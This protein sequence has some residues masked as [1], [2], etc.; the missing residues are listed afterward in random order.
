MQ[1]EENSE[2]EALLFEQN[3]DHPQEVFRYN[4]EEHFYTKNYNHLKNLFGEDD[5]NNLVSAI[6][7]LAQ[8]PEKHRDSILKSLEKPVLST[9]V[10]ILFSTFLPKTAE[11][12]SNQ[13]QQRQSFEEFLRIYSLG[14]PEQDKVRSDYYR[15]MILGRSLKDM[16]HEFRIEKDPENALGWSKKQLGELLLR[17]NARSGFDEE[18]VIFGASSFEPSL[19]RL[20]DWSTWYR[21]IFKKISPF[22]FE[23]RF[24]VEMPKFSLYLFYQ[25]PGMRT[26]LIYYLEGGFLD[27]WRKRLHIEIVY[28]LYSLFFEERKNDK[29][30]VKERVILGEIPKL[31]DEW[32]SRAREVVNAGKFQ[33]IW[34]QILLE[35]GI[36]RYRRSSI[37]F[38]IEICYSKFTRKFA[39]KKVPITYEEGK[40]GFKRL[41]I[42][43]QIF[44][45]LQKIK[46]HLEVCG[47]EIP[48]KFK[49]DTRLKNIDFKNDL[50]KAFYEY[51][52]KL[53]KFEYLEKE[54]S[55]QEIKIL[56]QI[57]GSE[58]KPT[59]HQIVQ[60]MENY[61][62]DCAI[63]LK[64]RYS[65]IKKR[66]SQK[67]K[68]KLPDSILDLEQNQKKRENWKKGGLLRAK[69]RLK[70]V[71][72]VLHIEQDRF[73]SPSLSHVLLVELDH[74]VREA[75]LNL[76]LVEF[77]VKLMQKYAK[78]IPWLWQINYEPAQSAIDKN[79]VYSL[80]FH[81][82]VNTT[83]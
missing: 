52:C 70:Y 61:L 13:A 39:H 77:L 55:E 22:A 38:I 15:K 49:T 43:A 73:A 5:L 42:L 32:E 68:E 24:D 37:K 1:I 51:L 83:H 74:F 50:Y 41:G 26:F 16:L 53:N 11:N 62:D 18:A 66:V 25:F 12:D 78:Y 76:K 44:N 35:K 45:H 36:E 59:I 47:P 4:L 72:S 80:R 19:E 10:K 79:S 6:K 21:A 33:F 58:V 69:E 82:E 31:A 9:L 67:L 71:K 7:Q 48:N 14:Y 57:K 3:L 29:V 23:K 54:L 60:K 2:F 65:H 56:N 46:E 63:S 20:R 64:F 28:I 27:T 17:T 34:T 81:R 8:D 40:K 30:T 75:E